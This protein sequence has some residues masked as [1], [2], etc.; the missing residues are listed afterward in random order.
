VTK[1]NVSHFEGPKQNYFAPPGFRAT[2]QKLW[3][4]A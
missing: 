4:K 3:G 1:Q 2:F